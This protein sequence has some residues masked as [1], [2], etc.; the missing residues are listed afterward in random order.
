MMTDKLPTHLLSATCLVSLLTLAAC[1]KQAEEIA[2][3]TEAQAPAAQSAAGNVNSARLMS[4]R[5]KVPFLSSS[6]HSGL[7]H[8]ETFQ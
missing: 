7:S 4:C 1:S 8:S 3:P 5:S 2:T 6:S